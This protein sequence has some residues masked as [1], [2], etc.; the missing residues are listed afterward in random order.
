MRSTKRRHRCIRCGPP[1]PEQIRAEAV[2]EGGEGDPHFPKK[3]R[4]AESNIFKFSHNV[5]LSPPF[6]F[7]TMLILNDSKTVDSRQEQF[8]GYQD[9]WRG[10]GG[11]SSP[12]FQKKMVQAKPNFFNTN[13]IYSSLPL[14]LRRASPHMKAF[15]IK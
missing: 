14:S 3:I 8:Q 13:T 9:R 5:A 4:R 6:I 12:I 11:Y 15:Q 7:F 1:P 10:E 2:K